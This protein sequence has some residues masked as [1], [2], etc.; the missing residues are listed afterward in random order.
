MRF[1]EQTTCVPCY[2]L[3][4]KEGRLMNLMMRVKEIYENGHNFLLDI[5][6]EA[7]KY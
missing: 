5:Q 4:F 6:K 7:L 2:K 1:G 3:K